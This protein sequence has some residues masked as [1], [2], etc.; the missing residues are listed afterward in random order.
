MADRHK[1]Y[2]YTNS[3]TQTK[4]HYQYSIKLFSP[5]FYHQFLSAGKQGKLS[6]QTNGISRNSYNLDMLELAMIKHWWKIIT[7]LVNI[8]LFNVCWAYSWIEILIADFWCSISA[9]FSYWLL[10]W[11]VRLFFSLF[12]SLETPLL[13]TTTQVRSQRSINQF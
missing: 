13:L 3:A 5:G 2:Q 12:L 7:T 4:Y 11:L 10:Y 1:T 6:G 9:G 8:N